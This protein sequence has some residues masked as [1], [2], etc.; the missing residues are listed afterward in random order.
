[1]FA[2]FCPSS[3]LVLAVWLVVGVS[4][5]M[6]P[7]QRPHIITILADD[8]G[9][10]DVSFHG[11]NQIP[12]PN[13]DALAYNGVIMNNHYVP[14]LCTPSRAAFMTGKYPTHTGMQHLVIL[15]PEPWGLPLHEKILP[16]HLKKAG[17]A[18]HAIGKWHLGF[19][20]KEYTPTFRGFDS[21]FGYWNG[22][23]DYY[24]HSMRATVD[25]YKG[26]DMRRNMSVDYSAAGKY[27]TDLFT[28]E[29][30][31]IINR[32]DTE[33]GPLF[34]YLSHL[35]PHT[36]NYDNPF[37]AP[38]EEIARFGHIEDPE[39]RVYAA[40]V[41]RLDRSV[42]EV[43]QALRSKRMLENSIVVF[44]S[45]NGAPTYGIHSNRGSNWP[46]RGQKHSPWEGGVRGVAAMWSPLI[47]QP[48]RVSNQMMH[49]IDWLPT[50]YSAAGMDVGDLGNIDGIDMWA[51]LSENKTSLRTEV[52]HNIDDKYNYAALTRGDWKYITGTTTGL[53]D[54]WYGESGHDNPA[55]PFY[56]PENVLRSKAGI[57]IA[58]LLTKLQ[59]KEKLEN[60]QKDMENNNLSYGKTVFSHLKLLTDST[61]FTLRK[62]SEVRCK[63][64]HPTDIKMECRP[65]ESPCLF[66]IRDD[67]CETTN[68]ANSRP[69]VLLS[70]EESLQKYRDSAVPPNNVPADPRANPAHHNGTWTSWQDQVYDSSP[71]STQDV[72][73]FPMRPS[74]ITNLLILIV[75]FTVIVM[76]AM[77]I[78]IRLFQTSEKSRKLSVFSIF[79]VKETSNVCEPKQSVK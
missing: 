75:L 16:Q 5:Q 65:K 54:N 63:I 53:W 15:A 33:Q 22:Y 55:I 42:G 34:L 48:Q 2:V 74:P 76:L 6:Q 60:K 19:F 13:I 51:S 17:Y 40:M 41:S 70:L 67:P 31:N 61:I 29:A 52:L 79:P 43:M 46:F 57:V 59:L 68:L 69:L 35:A 20:Q 23:Q 14:A 11:S 56:R 26:Y 18:T 27:S 77:V 9:W 39:R 73:M 1:M 10:N 12:T 71:K 28:D 7:N 21:H 50:L 62:Q 45:D 36:G 38:D 30:V 58:G 64:N 32:H 37:Q 25:P 47:K 8:L 78:V 66:N 3:L 72:D 4:S 44:M 24:D 49:M